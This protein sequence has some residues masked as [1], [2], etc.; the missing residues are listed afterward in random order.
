VS[1]LWLICGLFVSPHC[2]WVSM[3]KFVTLNI[4]LI[5]MIESYDILVATQTV[6]HQNTVDNTSID[7]LP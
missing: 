4:Q 3:C 2:F 6:T 5:V 7:T 1:Y